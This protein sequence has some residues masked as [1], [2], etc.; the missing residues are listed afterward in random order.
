MRLKMV[1]PP[2][3]PPAFFFGGRVLD[4]TEVGHVDGRYPYPVM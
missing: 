2:P 3:P 4:T 1:A